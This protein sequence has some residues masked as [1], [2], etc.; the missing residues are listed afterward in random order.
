MGLPGSLQFDIYFPKSPGDMFTEK[1]DTG[2]TL[3]I[4][5]GSVNGHQRPRSDHVDAQPHLVLFCLQIPKHIFSHGV[6]YYI[7]G[8]SCSKHH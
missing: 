4:L 8:P 3:H 1:E 2:Q 7:P 5:S 6:V